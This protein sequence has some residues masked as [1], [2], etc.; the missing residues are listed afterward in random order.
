M[1]IDC[2]Q[3]EFAAISDKA[4]VLASKLHNFFV[5]SIVHNIKSLKRPKIR[6]L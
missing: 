2:A 4:D 6:N 3:R 5:H 1:G